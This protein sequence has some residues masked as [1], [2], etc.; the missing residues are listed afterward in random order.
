ME[1][2]SNEKKAMEIAEKHKQECYYAINGD[3]D[4]SFEECYQSAIEAMEWKGNC[5]SNWLDT[6][7]KEIDKLTTGNLAH[8]KIHIKCLLYEIQKQLKKE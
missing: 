5:L 6:L 1:H 4:D 8:N 2:L 3:L 7:S